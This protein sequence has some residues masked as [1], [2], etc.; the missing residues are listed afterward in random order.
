MVLVV[1]LLYR[2]REIHCFGKTET[3]RNKPV[4]VSVLQQSVLPLD[5]S[6]QQTVLP[7]GWRRAWSTADFAALERVCSAAVCAVPR[8]VC[9]SVPVVCT[10]GVVCPAAACASSGRI[11]STA[12]CEMPGGVWLCCTWTV[13]LHKP[14]APG[15]VCLQEL[16][17]ALGVSIHK[18]L[19]CTCACPSTRAFVLHLDVSVYNVL[20]CTCACLSTIDLFCTLAC[21]STG[22][23]AAPWRICLQEPSPSCTCKC[24]LHKCTVY[25]LLG[26]FQLVSKYICLFQLFRYMFNISKQTDFVWFRE[27]NRKTS[28]TVWVSVVFVCFENSLVRANIQYNHAIRMTNICDL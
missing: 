12:G 16:L 1:R 2:N 6:V 13:S 8:L 3:I 28:G 27:I 14:A 7:V 15:N 10:P 19:C 22:V 25:N 18:S 17:C 11:C 20:F 23:S 5:V 4:D 21:L 24:T 26:L 9:V